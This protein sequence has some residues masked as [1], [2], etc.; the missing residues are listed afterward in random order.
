MVLV[1]DHLSA[2]VGGRMRMRLGGGVWADDFKFDLDF[3][4]A[5]KL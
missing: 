3:S 2:H 1:N 5:A 4:P